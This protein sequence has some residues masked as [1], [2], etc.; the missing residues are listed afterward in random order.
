MK[1]PNGP[2]SG[3]NLSNDM[4]SS[5]NSS[6][7]HISKK[8]LAFL[9]LAISAIL[10]AVNALIGEAIVNKS[11]SAA[12]WVLAEI[13][14]DNDVIKMKEELARLKDEHAAKIEHLIDIDSAYI[15]LANR[16]KGY[17]YSISK[18]W[19]K[20]N[21]ARV[22]KAD[23]ERYSVEIEYS[24]ARIHFR[25]IGNRFSD[26]TF[27]LIA[28]SNEY[29]STLSEVFNSLKAKNANDSEL[30]AML[31]PQDDDWLSQGPYSQL[32][33][34]KLKMSHSELINWLEGDFPDHIRSSLLSNGAKFSC[35]S[36]QSG[37]CTFRYPRFSIFFRAPLSDEEAGLPFPYLNYEQLEEFLNWQS[38]SAVGLLLP[39][40]VLRDTPAIVA[41]SSPKVSDSGPEPEVVVVEAVS[42]AEEV[43]VPVLVMISAAN[44]G[45]SS[46]DSIN[47][48]FLGKDAEELISDIPGVLESGRLV[49]LFRDW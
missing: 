41:D 16:D 32:G 1:K 21:N 44:F 25:C 46:I 5:L 8:R 11:L 10:T 6:L 13:N 26:T 33:F 45:E 17:C 22:T 31:Q 29:N 36:S 24:A 34:I 2:P 48:R 40:D 38:R 37:N 19:I 49:Q 12:Q 20:D 23:P 7:I 3:S 18:N 15:S 39:N 27:L 14:G 43:V 35:N 28:S 42:S 9:T 47:G 30:S 4:K